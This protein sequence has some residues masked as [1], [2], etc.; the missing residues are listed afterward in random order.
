MDIFLLRHGIA[1][2]WDS[3][4]FPDDSVRPLIPRGERKLRRICEAIQEMGL[5]FDVI[6]SSPF[7]RARRSAEIAGEALGLGDVLRLN[8]ELA[9]AGDASALIAHV[10]AMSP[11]P[12]KLLLVGHEPYLSRLISLLTTGEGNLAIE[13][14]KGGLARLEVQQHLAPGSCAVLKWLLTPRQMALMT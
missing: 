4:R 5:S 6:L 11:R 8:D 14:K 1:A 9:P 12:G 2:D 10:N 7:L 13:L 3:A